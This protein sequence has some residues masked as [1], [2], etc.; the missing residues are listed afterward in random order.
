MG[1][2]IDLRA[3]QLLDKKGF[4]DAYYEGVREGLGCKESF[5]KVNSEY[6]KYFRKPRYANYRSFAIIRDRDVKM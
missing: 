3:R 5:Q 2:L 6:E 4:I 1:E